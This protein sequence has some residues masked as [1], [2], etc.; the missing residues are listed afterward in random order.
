MDAQ[1]AKVEDDLQIQPSF[2]NQNYWFKLV[3]AM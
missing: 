2:K 1:I 3:H